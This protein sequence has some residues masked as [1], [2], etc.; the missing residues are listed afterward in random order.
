MSIEWPRYC[1]FGFQTEIQCEAASYLMSTEELTF[2]L[3]QT[4]TYDS[5]IAHQCNM[6]L[7]VTTINALLVF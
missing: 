3:Y 1:D 5:P 4:K 6:R 2:C 7:S